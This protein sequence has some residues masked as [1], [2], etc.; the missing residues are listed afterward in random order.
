MS[1]SLN[2]VMLIGNLGRDP[3]LRYTAGGTPVA[4][5]SV[6]T[7]ERWKGSDG[8]FQ[9]HTEWHN[10]VVWRR[11]AEVAGEYLR[12]GS[13]VY[14]EGK[15]RTRSWDGQD[16]QKR[17]K[18]EVMADTFIMLDARES[19]GGGGGGRGAAPAG[20]GFEPDEISDDD[21]PF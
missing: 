21:I 19:G 4:D 15:I 8:E 18:T 10:I 3:E 11:L 2:K 13:R 7:T 12:K 14:V 6:A 5:F 16:G 20:G 1:R 17:Y 9:E